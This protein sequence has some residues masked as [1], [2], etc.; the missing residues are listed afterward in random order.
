MKVRNVIFDLD[1]TLINTAEGIIDSAKYAME[2]LGLP[3]L[4]DSELKK[5]IGPP[6]KKSFINLLGC[7]DETAQNGV[8]IFREYYSRQGLLKAE[9]YKG[10][11]E[12]LHYLRNKD[13]HIAV[14]SYKR[15]DFLLRL[16][17]HFRMADV[18][19]SIH[20]AD[21]EGKLT[22]ED[23]IKKCMYELGAISD[24]TIMVGDS[25]SDIKSAENVG[26]GFIGVTYGFGFRSEDDLKGFA[27]IG[28]C[29]TP[30]NIKETI[31]RVL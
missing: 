25:G 23:I 31:V 9:P 27:H 10:I 8:N 22:K 1:G 7:D 6:L 2:K 29:E 15:E 16:L 18:F 24:E 12:L 13:I 17:T 14:A 19:D 28:L 11:V 30:E 4:D 21:I 3:L 5:I 26:I 20:G